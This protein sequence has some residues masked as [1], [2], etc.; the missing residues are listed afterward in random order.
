MYSKDPKG[1]KLYFKATSTLAKILHHINSLEDF[2]L[3]SLVA[4]G[5]NKQI[6]WLHKPLKY[7]QN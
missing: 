5:P 6:N 3:I 1:I 2:Q 7:M 4:K